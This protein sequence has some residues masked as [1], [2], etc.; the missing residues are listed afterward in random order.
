MLMSVQCCRQKSKRWG[1]A[2]NFFFNLGLK[3]EGEQIMSKIWTFIYK[4]AETNRPN[5]KQLHTKG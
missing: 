2:T 5:K 4:R 3:E 1:E